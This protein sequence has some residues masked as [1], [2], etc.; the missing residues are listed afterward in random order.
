MTTLRGSELVDG[1]TVMDNM[2]I[3]E[4][5]NHNNEITV[6]LLSSGELAVSIGE[7]NATVPANIRLDRKQMELL[8]Q[9]FHRLLGEEAQVN[10][11][12]R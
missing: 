6:G 3:L 10:S 1:V 9:Y 2:F 7:L 11:F 4:K 8:T 12:G 5:S